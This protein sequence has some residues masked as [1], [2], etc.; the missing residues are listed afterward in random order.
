MC[1]ERPTP[2]LP[3]VELATHDQSNA[4]DFSILVAVPATEDKKVDIFRLPSEQR[5]YTVPRVQ[6]FDTGEHLSLRARIKILNY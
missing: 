2:R 3:R 5:I 4:T 1:I 6:P